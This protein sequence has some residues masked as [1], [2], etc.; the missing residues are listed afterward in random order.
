MSLLLA[1]CDA[2]GPVRYARKVASETQTGCWSEEGDVYTLQ[3]EGALPEDVQG[4]G[5]MIDPSPGEGFHSILIRFVP[6][7]REVWHGWQYNSRLHNRFESAASEFL[8]PYL[9][10]I[11]E[12]ESIL[13][14]ANAHM[15]C[16]VSTCVDH[17][18]S[19]ACDLHR[20][21]LASM[22][23]GE[24]AE[25]LQTTPCRWCMSKH[26]TTLEA[27]NKL[28]RDAARTVTSIWN[29]SDRAI[30]GPTMCRVMD[31]LASLADAP[32]DE[33]QPR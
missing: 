14:A 11:T 24:F 4:G 31:H 13:E 27:E 5:A 18:L 22:T 2:W 33:S 9:A 7:E 1:R 19:D 17:L 30:A 28:L 20:K 16:V 12:L 8:A 3:K 21:E 25:K 29:M 23:F 15:D 26:V 6:N 10:R 32:H